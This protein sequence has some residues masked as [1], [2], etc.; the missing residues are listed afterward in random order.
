[1]YVEMFWIAAA[2]LKRLN[3]ARTKSEAEI[4]RLMQNRGPAFIGPYQ[5]YC[6]YCSASIHRDQN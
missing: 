2:E 5:N 3:A 6:L 1:M 4:A